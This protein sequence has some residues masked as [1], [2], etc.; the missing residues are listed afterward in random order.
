MVC[1]NPARAIAIMQIINIVNGDIPNCVMSILAL[2]FLG[3]R[4]RG[5]YRS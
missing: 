4:V 3:D 5:Y 2:V 1:T